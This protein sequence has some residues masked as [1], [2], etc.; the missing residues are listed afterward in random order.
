MCSGGLIEIRGDNII[1]S[2]W[3]KENVENDVVS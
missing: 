1:G 2:G 3:T